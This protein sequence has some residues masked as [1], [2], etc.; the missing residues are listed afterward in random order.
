VFGYRHVAIANNTELDR[1]GRPKIEG[2]RLAI[3]S[4]QAKTVIR[5][6]ERYAAGDSMKRIAMDLNADRVASP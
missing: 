1:Y 5:I 4:N 3:D 2:V 6:F